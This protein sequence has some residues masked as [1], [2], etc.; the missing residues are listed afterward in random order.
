MAPIFQKPSDLKAQGEVAAIVGQK[1]ECT[2]KRMGPLDRLDCYAFRG[3]T[4]LFFA[5]IKCRDVSSGEY[6]TVFLSF[7]KYLAMREVGSCF[8]LPVLYVIRYTDGV[9]YIDVMD[10]PL[11]QKLVAKGRPP[12]PGAVSDIE[13]IIE[14]PVDL[15]SPI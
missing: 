4:I 3:E 6:P 9:R 7:Q 5:E 1:W 15:M 10:L 13:P 12:R 11:P 2:L 8:G 14:I